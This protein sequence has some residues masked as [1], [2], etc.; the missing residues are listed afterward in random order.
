[1]VIAKHA[2][3]FKKYAQ[4]LTG[5]RNFED[6]L[7]CYEY[8][9]HTGRGK[10]MGFCCEGLKSLTTCWTTNLL[11]ESFRIAERTQSYYYWFRLDRSMKHYHLKNTE[12]QFVT[13]F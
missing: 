7:F 8:L 3:G 1:V 12:L 11:Q 2:H 9:Q 13:A 4:F 10:T 6:R 5:K